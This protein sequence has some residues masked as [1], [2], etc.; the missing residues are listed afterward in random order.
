MFIVA[1][2]NLKSSP[3]T[4]DEPAAHKVG[5]AEADGANKNSFSSNDVWRYCRSKQR[6][7]TYTQMLSQQMFQMATGSMS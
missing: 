3:V 1:F 2:R 5:D 7:G 6:L 4:S